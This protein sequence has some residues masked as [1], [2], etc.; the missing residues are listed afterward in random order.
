MSIVKVEVLVKA[1][2]PANEWG[3]QQ[4]DI[5]TIQPY[6]H[7]WGGG[8]LRGK[9]VFCVEM[10]IPCGVGFLMGN[11]CSSCEYRGKETCSV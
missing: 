9:F 11:R 3:T 4:Y 7:G 8:D 2:Q 1:Q 5:I 10:D 6:G